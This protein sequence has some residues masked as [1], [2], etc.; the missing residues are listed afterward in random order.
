MKI[1]IDKLFGK[2]VSITDTDNKTFVGAVF[3]YEDENNSEEGEPVLTI[4]WSEYGMILS[5]LESEITSIE[6]LPEGA[7]VD[8]SGNYDFVLGWKL[9]ADERDRWTF[10]KKIY[11]SKKR[12]SST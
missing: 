7:E 12:P 5:Y 8:Y 10:L 3:S 4:E 9:S 1:D 11:G 2:S 6:I